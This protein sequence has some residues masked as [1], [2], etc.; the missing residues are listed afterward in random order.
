MFVARMTQGFS[1]C[2]EG[3]YGERRTA[4][5]LIAL[6]RQ[7]VDSGN[8]EGVRWAGM[9]VH[10]VSNNILTKL[11]ASSKLNAEWAFFSMLRDE[12]RKSAQI[13]LQ[14]HALD[15]GRRS[16]VDLDVLLQGV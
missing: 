15:L 10:L 11:G 16:T 6:L 8:S 1:I 5:A 4:V 13:F 12:G 2:C 9:R 3:C 7:V 14:K